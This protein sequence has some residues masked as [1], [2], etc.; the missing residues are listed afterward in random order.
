M[1]VFITGDSMKL[2]QA[3]YDVAFAATKTHVQ[4]L[5]Q[6]L[7]PSWA[8]SMVTITDAEIRAVS[9]PTADAV[10]AAYIKSLETANTAK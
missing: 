3:V 8:Q 9:S 1:P 2:K 5:I 6:Q 4:T 10:V 7:V